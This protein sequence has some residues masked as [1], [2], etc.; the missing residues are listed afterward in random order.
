MTREYAFWTDEQNAMVRAVPLATNAR[1]SA[2]A[3]AQLAQIA[4][5]IGRSPAAVRTRWYQLHDDAH[6]TAGR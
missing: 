2:E 1:E 5:R 6:A 3:R 4:Q